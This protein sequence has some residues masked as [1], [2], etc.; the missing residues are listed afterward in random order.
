MKNSSVSAIRACLLL[1]VIFGF[2]AA[3]RA[4]LIGWLPASAHADSEYDA[5]YSANNAID[6]V[7][8]TRWAATGT[9]APHWWYADLGS[10]YDISDVSIAWEAGNPSAFTIQTSY[11]ATN[12]TDATGTL[13][14]PTSQDNTTVD[15]PLNAGANGQYIRIYSTS[16]GSY[17]GMSMW[18][19]NAYGSVPEPS[20]VVLLGASLIGLLV[21]RMKRR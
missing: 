17:N 20:S 12:W 15:Y 1:C 7:A 13:S 14:V 2:A 6:G 4:D 8:T 10:T 19:V 3:A 11:D 21:L 9:P 5:N 18:E 16:S